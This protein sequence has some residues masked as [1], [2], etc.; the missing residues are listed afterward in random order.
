VSF[1]RLLDANQTT[2]RAHR[3]PK[4]GE[5]APLTAQFQR[6]TSSSRILQL[7]VPREHL[8]HD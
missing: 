7:P 1:R 8:Y 2:I 4:C 6:T 5:I 3:P